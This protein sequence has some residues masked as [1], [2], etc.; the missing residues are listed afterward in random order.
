MC[1]RNHVLDAGRGPDPPREGALSGRHVGPLQGTMFS[2]SKDDE[3]RLSGAF[4]PPPDGQQS[5]TTRIDDKQLRNLNE[6]Q[7]DSQ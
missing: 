5:V 1:P 4:R 3:R 6:T 2:C 7:Q